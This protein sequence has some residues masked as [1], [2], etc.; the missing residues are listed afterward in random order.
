[1]GTLPNAA[2]LTEW[3]SP[4]FGLI[5][6]CGEASA[7]VVEHI[8]TGKSLSTSELTS[9]IKSAINS[10]Q[11]MGRANSF[12]Q[13]AENVQWDLGLAGVKSNVTFSP[14]SGLKSLLEN[15]L[16]AGK[17]VIL[18]VGRGNILSN[19]SPRVG[20]HYVT[21]VGENPQGFITAD[22]NAPQAQTGGFTNN[23]L[24]QLL[25]SAPFAAIVPEKSGAGPA[26]NTDCGPM[27]LP[28]NIAAFSQWTACMAANR[29]PQIASAASG[30]LDIPTAIAGIPQGLLNTFT[31]PFKGIGI[32]SFADFL[33]RAGI[34]VIALLLGLMGMLFILGDVV[35]SPK[36]QE[37]AKT[38]ATVAA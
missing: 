34:I 37:I 29:A 3:A 26:Q 33:W 22:P 6:G 20:G 10:G 35:S 7:M 8:V 1:M 9:L 19:E 32:T 23:S 25:N 16:A 31:N 5:V 27:P 15:S 17:P 30:I 2:A 24:Q 38:A 12:A 28:T 36:T 4:V 13:T 18:G 11:T 21:I 14:G